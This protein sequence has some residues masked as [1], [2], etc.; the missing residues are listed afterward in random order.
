M[1]KVVIFAVAGSGK[2]TH[3]VKNLSSQKRS[4]IVTYTNGNYENLSKKI[5]DHFGGR[6]PEN[7]TLMTYF[8]FLYCFCYKPF[9]ADIVRAKGITYSPPPAFKC[10]KTMKFFL[11]NGRFYSNRL[12][13]F[14]E[15]RVMDD[16]RNRLK[17]FYDEFI[18]DEIQDIDGRDF[19]FLEKLMQT[20]MDMLFVG[21]FYQHTF[22][23]SRDG[24]VNKDLFK[25]VCDYERRF[26]C[27]K[28]KIDKTTLLKSWRCSPNICKFVSCNLRI[29][30]TSNKSGADGIIQFISNDREREDIINNPNIVKLYLQKSDTHK[31]WCKNWGDTKGEDCYQDVCVMLNKKTMKMYKE[32]KLPELASGT[33]NK[34][35]VAITRAHRNVYLIEE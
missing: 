9:L 21:D 14:L 27:N 18:I 34:L 26:I 35:Y 10:K 7:V 30:I 8:H 25:S 19:N 20:P 4:L 17:K 28:V 24:N 22:S 13:H 3:I 5:V 16:I 1:D 32:G 11:S 2:T 23:T 15:Q 33:R 31:G 29:S 12:A 6:W